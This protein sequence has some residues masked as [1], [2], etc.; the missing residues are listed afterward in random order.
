MPHLRSETRDARA[1]A[2]ARDIQ[3]LGPQNLSDFD[4]IIGA[5]HDRL[6]TLER[7]SR[8]HGQTLGNADAAIT[9][10]RT[11]IVNVSDDIAKYKDYITST[12]LHWDT[13]LNEK[14][15][16]LTQQLEAFVAVL[17]PRVEVLT[18]RMDAAERYLSA[19]SAQGQDGGVAQP[20]G[21]PTATS[22]GAE[23][24][25]ISTDAAPAA[26]MPSYMANDPWGPS[27]RQ[28]FGPPQ[29]APTAAQTAQ[30]VAPPV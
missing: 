22:A 16:S 20:P 17:A 26:E 21:L 10:N 3:S 30:D 27:A 8:N 15:N 2:R 5:I 25:N 29:A 7:Y 28:R 9:E 19:G 14:W 24:F 6:D 12:H 4:A 11:A 23:H 13:L 1:E 18:S